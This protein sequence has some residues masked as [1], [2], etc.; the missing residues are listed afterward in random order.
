MDGRVAD[1]ARPHGAIGEVILMHGVQ[2]SL[3]RYEEAY[4]ALV[5]RGDPSAFRKFLL[6]A[7]AMFVETVIAP[8]RPACAMI[9]ASRS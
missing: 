6:S 4:Q 8:F 3:D 1:L 9:L 5:S 7:P 2:R